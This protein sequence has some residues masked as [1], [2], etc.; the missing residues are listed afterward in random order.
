[1]HTHDG[2]R[3]PGTVVRLPNGHM[4]CFPQMVIPY[5]PR[6][7]SFA[8]EIPCSDEDNLILFIEVFCAELDIQMGPF[9]TT[10]D[11]S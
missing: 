3:N 6:N 10:L 7:S 8:Y 4:H 2:H 1:M 9:Q 5:I 11:F